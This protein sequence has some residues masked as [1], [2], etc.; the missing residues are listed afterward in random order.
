MTDHTLAVIL[1]QQQRVT[2][3]KTLYSVLVLT[4]HKMRRAHQGQHPVVVH[5]ARILGHENLDR[6][7]CCGKVT[8]SRN[9]HLH[10]FNLLGQRL[11]TVAGRLHPI[12]K[13]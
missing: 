3:V 7:H 13:Q 9:Y 11:R 4:Q 6:G 2:L 1:I 8:L 10:I 12:I 5:G